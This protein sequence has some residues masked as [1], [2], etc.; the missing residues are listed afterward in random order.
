[1]YCNHLI[2]TTFDS[3]KTYIKIRVSGTCKPSEQVVPAT[4]WSEHRRAR[5]Q[6]PGYLNVN[7]F[8]GSSRQVG[9]EIEPLDKSRVL[10]GDLQQRAEMLDHLVIGP[11]IVTA[12][13]IQQKGVFSF[14]FHALLGFCRLP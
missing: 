8:F 3:L 4:S 6:E 14:Y 10:L 7:Q 2:Y 12:D 1:M 11:V 13:E 5:L 9:T